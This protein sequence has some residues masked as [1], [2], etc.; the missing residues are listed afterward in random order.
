MDD[1]IFLA[2]MVVAALCALAAMYFAIQYSKSR[3][4]ADKAA[5]ELL[6]LRREVRLNYAPLPE[7]AMPS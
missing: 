6:R 3:A 5:A 1:L 2:E 4:R 7:E